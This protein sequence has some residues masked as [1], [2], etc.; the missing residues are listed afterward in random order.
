MRSLIVSSLL[1][2]SLLLSSYAGAQV[3]CVMKQYSLREGLSDGRVLCSLRD[4]EGFMWFGTFIGL[5][6]FD[7]YNFKTYKSYPGDNSSLKN[8]RI[9]DILEDKDGF[10]W[11]LADDEK[12]Y[13][14]DKQKETFHALTELVSAPDLRSVQVKEIKS[15]DKRN[16]WLRTNQ[17]L[18]LITTSAAEKMKVSHYSDTTR[19]VS[20][21]PPKKI[22]FFNLPDPNTVYVGTD[23]GLLILKKRN[24]V[25]VPVDI[26]EDLSKLHYTSVSVGPN[27]AC[28]GTFQG[29]VVVINRK[30]GRLTKH[31]LSDHIIHAVR[32]SANPGRLYCTTAG[33]EIISLEFNRDKPVKRVKI[34]NQSLFSLFEDSRGLLWVEPQRSGILKYDPASNVSRF[35]FYPSPDYIIKENN[36]YDY[37]VLEDKQG[38]VWINQKGSRFGCYNRSTGEIDFTYDDFQSLNSFHPE[39]KILM[40]DQQ[41]VLWLT[42]SL[43]GVQKCVISRSPFRQSFIP[44]DKITK[45]ENNIRGMFSDRAGRLWMGTRTGRLYVMQNEKVLDG[46]L[47]GDIPQ[48]VYCI[49]EDKRGNVWLGTKGFGLFKAEPL[50]Q[51][52]TRYRVRRFAVD[53]PNS[54]SISSNVIYSLLEDRAGRIWAGSFEKGLIMVNETAG[55]TSFKTIDNYFFN[56]PREAHSRVR[57]LAEDQ[58]GNIWIGTTGGL[59]VFNPQPAN[60]GG[61]SFRVYRKEPN[62]IKSLGDDDVQFIYRNRQGIMWVLTSSGGLN[63]AMGD[64]LKKLEFVNYSTRNGLANDCLLSCVEDDAGNLWLGAQNSVSRFSPKT[65]QIRNFDTFDGLSVS[66]ISEASCVKAKDGSILFGTVRGY[67]SF[68]PQEVN[69]EKVSGTIVLTDLQINNEFFLAGAGMNVGKNVNYLDTLILDHHQNNI[70]L[71]YTLL[72]YRVEDKIQYSFRLFGYDSKW[73]NNRG[74]RRVTYTNLEPGTYTFEVQGGDG[75]TYKNGPLKRLTIVIKPPYW[76]TSWAYLLYAAVA[77]GIL[78]IVKHIATT[79]LRLRRDIAVEKQMAELKIN[80]FTQASHEIRTPLSLVINPLEEVIRNEDLSDKGR[81]YLHL[82]LR[83]AGRMLRFFNQLLDLRKVQSGMAEL[84]LSRLELIAFLR[85]EAGYFVEAAGQR[86]IS[87]KILSEMTEAFVSVDTEK[88]DIVIYNILSNALKFSPDN[89]TVTII[90]EKSQGE[91]KVRIKIQDEGPGVPEAELG[92][93]FRLYYEGKQQ[94]ERPL[95]GT[96]IGLALAKELIELHGAEIRAQNIRPRGFVVEVVLPLLVA[97]EHPLPAPVLSE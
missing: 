78:L 17:G 58:Q 50:D 57:S 19:S 1:F 66:G 12:V 80:F 76:K 86:N 92:N 48:R 72:D 52:R 64:A 79:M 16:L 27:Y 41:N 21:L 65:K 3:R 26:G 83:N 28:F 94:G 88:M 87:I 62:N 82:V 42:S 10:L 36:N 91:Q 44:G 47:E 49:L 54:S 14:F 30:T 45:E 73:Q 89:S 85:K 67:F 96:G 39:V 38:N 51:G 15:A 75:G 84:K 24:G 70:S 95:K 81:E 22:R 2:F 97:T 5:C 8:N 68:K 35:Y 7:G 23:K 11:L 56:Y 93:I 4:R 55:K 34:E 25:F 31:K 77:L 29:Y 90:V 63:Q 71:F 53:P 37:Q 18:Y 46:L 32:M 40:Y 20:T 13:R 74:A 33:K 60:S 61:G 6:R 59:L 69:S 43:G 9:N